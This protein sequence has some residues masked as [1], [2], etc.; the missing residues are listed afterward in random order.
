[1]IDFRENW[2]T[3]TPYGQVWADY[4]SEH[5]DL[6][7]GT[8]GTPTCSS[9]K[10]ASSTSCPSGTCCCSGSAAS[11]CDLACQVYGN[12]F[13]GTCQAGSSGSADTSPIGMLHTCG[14]KYVMKMTTS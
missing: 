13:T 14:T 9:G 3:W 12:Q 1:M 11:S 7:S 6:I 5:K 8:G 2:T 10:T 4:T